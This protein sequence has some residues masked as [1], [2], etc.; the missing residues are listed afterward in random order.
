MLLF[1]Y[2]VDTGANKD[3]PERYDMNGE[4]SFLFAPDSALEETDWMDHGSCVAF[5]G[6]EK[7][8]HMAPR[9]RPTWS[10]ITCLVKSRSIL[11]L[12]P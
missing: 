10:R 12:W 1:T 4:N 7:V 11:S 8:Q 5:K 6:D 2:I 9:S 3:D